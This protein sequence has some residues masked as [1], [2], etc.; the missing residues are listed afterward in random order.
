MNGLHS[1]PGSCLAW[2]NPALASVGSMVALTVN[3]KKVYTKGDLQ[4]PPFLCDPLL[5]HTST[6]GPLTQSSVGHCSSPLGFSV[7][8]ILFVSSKTVVIVFLSPLDTYKQ[9]LL[10]LK[11]RFPGNSQ[12]LRQIPRLG[13]LTWGSEPSQQH[14]NVF[15]IIVFQ[16]VGHPPSGYGIWFYHDCTPPTVSLRLSLF[17]DT[18]YLF[19][20]GSSV[21][22][23]MVFNS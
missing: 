12:S 11:A 13:S 18:G 9:I 15:G 17:L 3:S 19:L 10:A 16:S 23:S 4:V 21:L 2:G 1:L 6:V 8:K 7:W 20:V 22:L 14:E 5:T